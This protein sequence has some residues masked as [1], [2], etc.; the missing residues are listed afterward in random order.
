M[1]FQTQR[2]ERPDPADLDLTSG[3]V[4]RVA[5]QAKDPD[6]VS[7]FVDERFAFGLAVGLA[8]EAG[9]RKGL[10]LT[11]DEQ[12]ALL[13]R[14]EAFGAKAAALGYVADRAR[15]TTEV[16]QSLERRGFAEPVIE[17]ALAGLEAS[18]LL[19]DAAY[20]TAYARS[21][22]TGPGYGPARIRQDL[23]RRGVDRAAI[24]AA[25]AE[26]A[27]AE[28]VGARAHG[29]AETKWRALASE[30]D[31]RKR[32]RKTME[33]LVRRGHSF[34]DARSAAEAA[35]AADPDDGDDARWEE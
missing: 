25:L 31:R 14:Q 17:D 19:D 2:T 32:I 16:R 1:A 5:Q 29:D 9:L 8:V 26:L 4:T 33:F 13:V 11:A 18:G 22:F 10:E 28:D 3:T 12:R 21:R 15:T 35:S 24:D 20:A 27:E 6:R 23:I 30:P 7:V 34:D